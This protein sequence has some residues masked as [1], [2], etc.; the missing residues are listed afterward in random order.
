MNDLVKILQFLSMAMTLR[1]T[2]AYVQ[3]STWI[4]P[5]RHSFIG[6]AR[7]TQMRSYLSMSQVSYAKTLIHTS[8]NTISKPRRR[9]KRYKDVIQATNQKKTEEFFI[10]NWKLKFKILNNKSTLMILIPPAETFFNTKKQFF[11]I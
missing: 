1:T 2:L 5:S 3:T 9:K 6:W 8:T 4:G 7:I 10:N 11:N